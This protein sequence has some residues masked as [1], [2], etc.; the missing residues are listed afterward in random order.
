M[1]RRGRD[2]TAGAVS[3]AGGAAARGAGASGGG[4]PGL[5][6]LV[7]AGPGDPGLLTERGRAALAAADDVVYDAL[8]SERIVAG[9]G[10]RRHFVGKRA[11][12]QALPQA[13][14]E[15][16]L[17]RLARAG[18]RVCRLKGGDPFLFG[19]GGEEVEALERAGVAYQV[20]PGVTAALGAAAYCGAPLT[21]RER[22]SSVA[23]CTGH[24]EPVPV[25]AA[26]TIVYY[27]A[28]A[29]LARVAAAVLA[30]GWPA[31]TPVLIVRDATLPQQRS[32]ATDLGRIRAGAVTAVSP[33]VIVVGGAAARPAADGRAAGGRAAGAGWY[34]QRRKV[35]VT[36]LRAEPFAHLG[37]VIH[38]PLIDT[39]PAADPTAVRSA[40]G[41]LGAGPAAGAG[42]FDLIAFASRPAVEHFAR[43][44]LDAGRDARALAGAAIAASGEATAAALA[45][46]GLRADV[47]GDGSGAGGLE[48]ACA[49]AG[50]RG[51]RILLP[52]SD[53]T[54]PAL[55]DGLRAAGARVEVVTCYRTV[56]RPDPV[57]QEL[58]G[59]D[60]AAF[61]SPSGVAAF[62]AL[63]GGDPPAGLQL[64][65][66]GELTA[67]AVR[68]AYPNRAV[69]VLPRRP[70]KFM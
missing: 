38:T 49:A 24:A 52:A 59:I 25:P 21:H 8:V 20:I 58:A 65:A 29:Q 28:A 55:A 16:L 23:F 27:M 17:I 63:Y 37:E 9:C 45:R 46:F 14:I 12:A 33:S 67:Q 57:R 48:R 3:G 30:A 62:R 53:L 2:R 1:P 26:D 13:G 11:G 66:L 35:L 61:S 36:G 19:R 70:E 60:A 22:S 64:L 50:V 68:N 42:A 15:A 32:T 10:G 7:G 31:S 4:G 51:A 54:R 43:E 47:T 18:R 44:L 39:A 34:A 69:R 56:P 41:R 40:I 6:T 5:V